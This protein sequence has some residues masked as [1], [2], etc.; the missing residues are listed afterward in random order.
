[1]LPGSMTES[2]LLR[3]IWTSAAL[4]LCLA[5]A[6]CGNRDSGWHGHD[7]TG[8]MPDLA[9]TMQRVN[10]GQPVTAADYRG[11]VTLLYFGYT[12]CPDICPTTLAN[13]SEALRRLG[14]KANAVRVL[15]V[16]VDPD[17]DTL[18]V[19]K[20]YVHAFAPEMDGLRGSKDAIAALARRYRVAYTVNKPTADHP[21]E[22]MHSAAVF[23]FDVQGHARLVTLS[24]DGTAAVAADIARLEK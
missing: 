4:A 17:R 15:F 13:L 6:A 16:T 3:R 19:L 23:F 1:M 22:V 9:F 7:I 21:Y 5:L 14:A 24:T 10:D 12:N 2:A 8:H 20:A 11:K 18:P